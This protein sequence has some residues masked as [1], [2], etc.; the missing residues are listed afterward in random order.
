MF[1]NLSE[2]I[3][4]NQGLTSLQNSNEFYF[5][6][7]QE[8]INNWLS[9]VV[10]EEQ[11][12]ILLEL[13]G[14]YERFIQ[15]GT[16]YHPEL[17]LIKDLLYTII[18]Y[19]DEK[20]RN[21]NR[22]NEYENKRTLARAGVRMGP[23]IKGI[24][25]Y[26]FNKANVTGSTKNAFDF[27]IDPVN[28]STILSENHRSFIIQHYLSKPYQQELFVSD[29]KEIFKTYNLSCANES[30]Y[31]HL[32]S[33]IV[34]N[35][36]AEWKPRKRTTFKELIEELKKYKL[37]NNLGFNLIPFKANAKYIW[38]TDSLDIIGN[39]IA[40]YEV[41]TRDIKGN[42][43]TLYI[44]VHFESKIKANREVFFNTISELP[45][46]LEWIDWYK[47]KSIGYKE[48]F[49]ISD[50]DNL[51]EK[52]FNALEYIEETIGETIRNIIHSIPNTEEKLV[53]HNLNN[54]KIMESPLNQI[55]FGPP[56]TGKT[57]NTINEALQI[58]DPTYYENNKGDRNKLT[59]R[60]K[61]L[62]IK[63]EDDKNGQIGFCTFHQSFSYE[64]FVEG[65]KPKT[66][67]DKNVYY[68]IESGIFKRICQLAD[69]YNSTIKVKKE[70]KLSWDI[71]Q[72]RKASFYKLSLGAIYNPND[73]PIYE[74]CR[75]NSLIA[76]GFG[77]E[78]DFR[79]LSESEIE[80]KCKD[81]NLE[82]TT[83][84]QLNYFIHYL[85]KGNY[86]IIGNGNKY[87]KAIGKVTGDYEYIENSPIQYNHFRKV[88]WVF[89]DEN[90]P[91]EEIYER[92]L[93]QKTMYKIDETALKM[94]F[95][96]NNGHETLE[97]INTEEKKY[98]LIIDEI[99]R[100]NVSSIFG[101]LITLI[102]KDKRAGCDEELEVILPY[103]KEPFKVPKN[104]FII[105][106]MNTADRSVEALDTAL[107]RRFSFKEMM[108][109]EKVITE[110]NFKDYDRTSIMN[111]I[112]QRIE[113]L[114]DRNYTLG[115]SYFIKE[116]FKNSFQNE[117]IPLLQE[118]F[119]ND[120]GKIGLVLGKG[121]VREK[122][123]T[124]KNDKSIFADFDTKNEVDIV[125]SYELIPFSE[126]NFEEAT[127]T[128]LV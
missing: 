36:D 6:K 8:A 93:S 76:M 65:I 28:N 84:Q 11:K 34:Y 123:I 119:Y 79:G 45:E 32:L 9:M 48:S 55:L 74:Y 101:E 67:D 105:G 114:L 72:F 29:L 10:P 111:L 60:F 7:G 52:I 103:S 17:I 33:S 23:W 37:E 5:Q 122:A 85:K 1:E 13:S 100:G 64:D 19:C 125:K 110:K 70:G 82:P 68:D 4:N 66:T 75:D 22:F 115:H 41:S 12:T 118:Y 56:G 15:I 97:N 94:D 81:L 83:A 59:D 63:S 106:T 57:F 58:V 87:V 21:K 2:L 117:I 25:E 69:S 102:E 96:T 99:N 104:V 49:Q 14:N 18:S 107:R 80:E 54:F 116:D 62:L 40:H 88:E 46:D 73:K 121:F 38:L 89:V 50:E 39:S 126:I 91:I 128:L 90:I 109:N 108:P 27:L 51:A 127:Q 86:V 47:S 24:I 44:D 53:K 113:V 95:F 77:N 71:E 78:N 20:A 30:N 31:T 92:G 3:N 112:N 61:E 16:T 124:A 120:Y 26:K 98:V 35:Y 43:D 42:K